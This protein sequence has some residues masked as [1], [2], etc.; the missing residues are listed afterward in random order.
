MA[1]IDDR[2]THNHNFLK[3]AG[4]A[5]GY[6][7]AFTVHN[8]HNRRYYS[9]IDATILLNGQ[10]VDELVFLQWQVNEQTMPLF[11][12]NSYLWDD[13]AK[14]NR[15]V[16][17][18]FGINFTVPDYLNQLIAGQTENSIHFEN[19]GTQIVNDAHAPIYS[20][21][22]TICVGYGQ[23]DSLLGVAPCTFLNNVIVQATGQML[24]TEGQN[25]VETYNFIARD[26]NMS[27]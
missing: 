14:G 21:G 18:S 11:G 22:F 24:S 27:R 4:G 26:R 23:Q 1:A 6:R 20:K 3:A 13:V 17:G 5:L 7:N 19:N 16:T 9:S 25:L 8:H 12:Y 2:P 10:P 15:Y